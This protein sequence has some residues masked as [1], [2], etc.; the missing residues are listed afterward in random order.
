MEEGLE[1]GPEAAQGVVWGEHSVDTWIQEKSSKRLC[2]MI[3][4]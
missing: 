1:E 2:P 3:Q 4:M